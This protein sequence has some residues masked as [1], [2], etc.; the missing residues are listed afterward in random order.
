MVNFLLAVDTALQSGTVVGV[1]VGAAWTWAVIGVATAA[2]GLLVEVTQELV[3]WV[4]V[5]G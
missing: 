3:F 5:V 4:I 2:V 1:A